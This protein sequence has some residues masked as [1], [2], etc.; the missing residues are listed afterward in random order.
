MRSAR[1]RMAVTLELMIPSTTAFQLLDSV[2]RSGRR[3][4]Y[5]QF[6]AHLVRNDSFGTQA[7]YMIADCT[8]QYTDGRSQFI[9]V[10]RAAGVPSVRKWD[11]VRLVWRG[12]SGGRQAS[13]RVAGDGLRRRICLK[14]THYPNFMIPR[15]GC[16]ET[17]DCGG[18]GLVSIT[19]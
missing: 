12:C 19:Q 13:T 5:G 16:G 2:A 15:R 3:N 18:G 1:T 7:H 8:R 9:R 17:R 10:Y 6:A 11:W 4:A 14:R